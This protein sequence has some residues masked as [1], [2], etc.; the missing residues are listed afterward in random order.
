MKNVKKLLGIGA[1]VAAV[2]GLAYYVYK[3]VKEVNDWGLDD[4]E[5]T[6]EDEDDFDDF[7]DFD[8][9]FDNLDEE[10]EIEVDE[11]VVAEEDFSEGIPEDNSELDT[12]ALINGGTREEIIKILCDAV[13]DYDAETLREFNDAELTQIYADWKCAQK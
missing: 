7:D 8:E 13:S 2:A 6:D 3:K 9:D 5:D 10:D 1:G 11:D 4:E 12:F